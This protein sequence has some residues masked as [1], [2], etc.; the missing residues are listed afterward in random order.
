[1]PKAAQRRV[2]VTP[3]A[4]PTASIRLWAAFV[5][6]RLSTTVKAVENEASASSGVEGA[7]E[8]PADEVAGA[9]AGVGGGAELGRGGRAQEVRRNLNG[10]SVQVRLRLGEAV[11]A[12]PWTSLKT[13]ET[14]NLHEF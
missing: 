11:G 5:C 4:P 1:M 14:P 6:G 3:R 2:A 10:G 9:L 8:R 13:V 12:H 7:A